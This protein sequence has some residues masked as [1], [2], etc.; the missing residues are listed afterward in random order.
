MGFLKVSAPLI[1]AATLLS[2]LAQAAPAPRR[3]K[4]RDYV[5]EVVTETVWT[6]VDITTTVYV[7][8]LPATSVPAT[9]SAEVTSSAEET[10]AEDTTSAE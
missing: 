7:D 1:L 3:L 9:A 2:S 8:E 10:S 4:A 6:T 5:T